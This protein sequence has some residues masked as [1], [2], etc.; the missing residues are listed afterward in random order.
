MTEKIKAY[1]SNQFYRTSLKSDIIAGIIV[2]FVSI[3]ISMG[4]A[5]VAGLPA[6]YG[7]YGSI[8]PILLY[9]L[10]SGSR[11]FV[12]GVDAMPAAMVGAMLPVLG[13][14]PDSEEALILVP[15]MSLLVAVWFIVFYAFRAGRVVKYISNPVMGGFITGVGLTIIMMQ[16]P[17]L[18]GGSAGTGEIVVLVRNIIHQRSGYNLVSGLLGIGTVVIILYAKK[19]APK[20]PMS[21]LLMFLSA[22]LAYFVPLQ[23]YGVKLLPQV[24]AKLF[25][26][27]MPSLG[28]LSKWGWSGFQTL[29]VE[30]LLIALV[31]MAQTLLASNSYGMKYDYKIDSGRE[32]LSYS[33]MNGASCLCGCCP[34]NGSVSRTGIADQFGAKS[35]TMSIASALTMAVVLAFG[36]PI[37]RYLPVP[38]LT[39]IVMGALIGILDIK[40]AKRLFKSNRQE[41]WIFILAMGGVLVF[42]TI[43]GVVLGMIL[44]FFAVIVRAVVP[45]TAFLG[46]I[47]GHD[48]F[49]N[50]NRNRSARPI[51]NTVIYRFGGNLFFA[52]IGRFV[53]DIEGA[54][55]QYPDTKQV[56]VDAR[57]IGNVDITAADRLVAL[58]AKLAKNGIK[59][60]MTEHVGTVNDM[61]RSY[62]AGSLLEKGAIRRTISLALRDAGVE[63][64]YPLVG[65]HKTEENSEKGLHNTESGSD[66]NGLHNF[67]TSCTT[68]D[69]EKM[70]YVEASERLAEFEWAF[71]Q[72]AEREMELIAHQVAEELLAKSDHLPD[73]NFEQGDSSGRMKSFENEKYT[74]DSVGVKEQMENSEERLEEWFEELESH[75]TFGKV[76][77]F[78]ED[79]LLDYLEIQLEHMAHLSEN[80]RKRIGKIISQRR[81]QIQQK[82]QKI[83]PKAEA[84]IHEHRM[85]LAE[86]LKE[87]HPEEYQRILEWEKK[88]QHWSQE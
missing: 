45:P 63:K 68:V 46:Q 9:G 82:L 70:G 78:D 62:G 79:E 3:P 72:D 24:E 2:A 20:F 7:L 81:I 4:Y 87:S 23:N 38:V 5:Q 43:Y 66:A 18:L 33:V 15:M 76:G 60:Y 14:L 31:V 83:N 88:H 30:S 19:I 57:G 13:V 47:P 39:G 56:I 8:L 37:F 41:F 73:F 85:R 50:L 34:V 75:T 52:N 42:G 25:F 54:L 71:G 12:V 55:E 28:I 53:E 59:F 35:H 49:Y 61:L 1:L 36:T 40:Q 84:I 74:S 64:P 16:I 69:Q 77:L 26:L 11:Q 10:V 6:V 17:K 51:Q 32:L 48:D 27:K 29:L 58:H 80:H 21:V 22:V 44:S 86:H 65:L 67:E